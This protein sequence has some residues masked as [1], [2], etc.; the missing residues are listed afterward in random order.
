M[1]AIARASTLTHWFNRL[2]IVL[3]RFLF[4]VL[5]F[6]LRFC[7]AGGGGVLSSKWLVYSLHTY[8]TGVKHCKKVLHWKTSQVL[9]SFE[10]PIAWRFSAG[11]EGLTPC[12]PSLVVSFRALSSFLKPSWIRY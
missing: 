6:V 10:K 12:E 8:Q 2:E 11:H 4:F 3:S 9:V 1:P 7:F 5:A